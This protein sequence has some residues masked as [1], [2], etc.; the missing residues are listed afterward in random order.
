MRIKKSFN[1]FYYGIALVLFL[2]IMSCGVDRAEQVET[3]NENLADFEKLRAL[4]ESRYQRTFQDTTYNRTRIVF[5]N[6]DEDDVL[7]EQDYFCDDKV[8]LEAMDALGIREMAFEK[9]G[10]PCSPES[11]F[12]EIYCRI[13]K[14]NYYPVVTYLYEYCGSGPVYESKTTFYQPVGS[15]WGVLV[16]SHFP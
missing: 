13:K 14:T 12:N 8:V 4:V 1:I 11:I 9:T 7:N 15:N 5:I 3:L 6:C 2:N 10:S 16:D